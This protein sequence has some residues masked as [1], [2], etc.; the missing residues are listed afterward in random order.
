MRWLLACAVVVLAA[1]AAALAYGMTRTTSSPPPIQHGPAPRF[2]AAATWPAGARLAP[3]FHLRDQHGAPI[4]PASLRGRPAVVTFIDPV[5][6]N[7]CP[8]EAKVLMQAVHSLPAADRPAIVSV[9]VNPWED[10][11]QNFALDRS[12]W[13]LDASWRWA[14]GSHAALAKVW[15]DYEIAVVVQTKKIQGVTVRSIA[16]TEASYVVDRTGHERA[17]FVYPFKAK[18]VAQTLRDVA[19]G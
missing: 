2:T 10:T 6:R 19:T 3:A 1:L 7:L 16:H 17:V 13:R 14:V 18:D 9:S 4:S 11:Q 12:H 5:C 8:L 15:K